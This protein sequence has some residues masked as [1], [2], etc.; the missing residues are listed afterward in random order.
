MF[1]ALLI[2]L[3]ACEQA[4]AGQADWPTRAVDEFVQW[5]SQVRL[6]ESEQVVNVW[7]VLNRDTD[8]GYLVADTREA[9]ARLYDASGRL[10]ARFGARGKGPEEFDGMVSLL[11]LPSGELAVADLSGKLA[12]FDS[13]GSRLA[14]TYQTGLLPLYDAELLPDSTLLLV[15]R[16]KDRAGPLLHVFDPPRGA[17]VRSFFPDGAVRALGRRNALTAGWVEATVRADTIAVVHSLAD[18]LFLFSAGGRRLRATPIPFQHFRRMERELPRRPTRVETHAWM[19]SFSLVSHAFWAG[20]GTWLIQYQDRDGPEI[21][22]RLL[23]MDRDG[24]R[25]FELRDP[26]QLLATDPDRG[27]LYFVHPGSLAPN[28]WS[29]ARLR[30]R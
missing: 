15:G 25:R 28:Q 14:R 20:D 10:R 13:A 30:S 11:R 18:T 6:E 7:P 8:G 5:E 4:E 16:G 27:R 12:V 2:A 17:V 21:R 26:P 19:S 22:W 3:G 23:A 9:Q 29:V 24:R 1:I